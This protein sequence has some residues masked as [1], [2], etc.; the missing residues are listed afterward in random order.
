GRETELHETMLNPRLVTNMGIGQLLEDSSEQRAG[1]IGLFNTD[2]SLLPVELASIKLCREVELA[3]YN[4]YRD[5]INYPRVTAFNQISSD[6]RVQSEL[7][8]LYNNDVDRIDYFVGLFAEDTRANSI[9][10]GMIGRLVAI[11]A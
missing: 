9:M 5:L 7:A 2:K 1:K 4:D 3:S 8:R 10:G 6:P 11:D